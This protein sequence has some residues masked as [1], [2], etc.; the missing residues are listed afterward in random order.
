MHFLSRD[1]LA[2]MVSRH[3]SD[4][5]TGHVREVV[6]VG[7]CAADLDEIGQV[8]AAIGDEDSTA[9]AR[10]TILA[11]QGHVPSRGLLSTELLREA[12]S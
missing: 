3:R 4:S 1:Y 8:R 10:K 7:L 12:A 2:Y 5:R 11:I 9:G 6:V